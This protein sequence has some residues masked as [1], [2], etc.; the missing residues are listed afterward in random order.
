[1][2][3]EIIGKNSSLKNLE[4]HGIVSD[5][6]AARIMIGLKSRRHS[7][8]KFLSIEASHLSSNSITGLME[9]FNETNLHHIR[10]NP[11]LLHCHTGM[12]DIYCV[13]LIKT[14][15]NPLQL[16]ADSEQVVTVACTYLEAPLAISL[17]SF[18][19]KNS[20]PVASLDLSRNFNKQLL[21]NLGDSGNRVLEQMLMYNK[22]I[23]TLN[24]CSL[25]NDTVLKCIARGM[26]YNQNVHTIIITISGVS[27]DALCSLLLSLS[28]F[29]LTVKVIDDVIYL[30][31]RISETNSESMDISTKQIPSLF[32]KP[33]EVDLSSIDLNR[34]LNCLNSGINNSDYP[35]EFEL[36][37]S[38]KSTPDERIVLDSDTIN[39]SL[40]RIKS[41]KTLK[42]CN[43]VTSDVISNLAAG[44]DGNNTLTH[45]ALHPK[46]LSVSNIKMIFEASS[47]IKLEFINEFLFF[48][49]KK[50]AQW[51]LEVVKIQPTILNKL[52]NT[53]GIEIATII[54]KSEKSITL[55]F[56]DVNTKLALSLLILRSMA[57]GDYVVQVLD[58]TFN[59]DYID[60][61]QEYGNAIERMLRSCKS[62]KKLTIINL[63]ND[64]IASH[65]IKG[66]AQNSSLSKL[67][68]RE[69]HISNSSFVQS[70]LKMRIVSPAMHTICINNQISLQRLSQIDLYDIPIN[71]E[72]LPRDGSWKIMPIT[73]KNSLLFIFCL[74]NKIMCNACVTSVGGL[75][76]EYLQS[77][78]LSGTC[79]TYKQL[80]SLF[81]ELQEN[82][83]VINLDVSFCIYALPHNQELN[84]H[85]TLRGMLERN[86]TIKTLNLTG[87][88]DDK[89]A[90]ILAKAIPKCSLIAL[91]VNFTT[92]DYS[93]HEFE[94]LLCSFMHSKHLLT[95]E[96]TNFCIIQRKESLI[97][98]SLL[99]KKEC[100][101]WQL[102][103]NVELLQSWCILFMFHVLGK[104]CNVSRSGLCISVNKHIND[105]LMK[106]IFQMFFNAAKVDPG[107]FTVAK[108][109]VTTL[110]ELHLDITVQSFALFS[111]MIEPFT[112]LSQ[113]HLSHDDKC[114]TYPMLSCMY[115]KLISS[116]RTLEL[117]RFNGHFRNEM[118]NAIAEGLSHNDTL[119]TLQF[120]ATL[121]SVETL[122]HLFTSMCNSSLTCVQIIEGCCLKRL[123]SEQPFD[124]EFTGDK[125]LLCKLF[126]ASTRVN[127]KD[128]SFLISPSLLCCKELDLSIDS[129]S[130]T[131][132]DIDFITLFTA[133]M[134]GFISKLIL[135][136]NKIILNQNL[137]KPSTSILEIL[138]LD[139]CHI[140][141]C[142]CEHIAKGLTSNKC[143]KVL[144]LQHN[145]IT[146]CGA[147][148]ILSSLMKNN[149]LQSLHLSGNDLTPIKVSKHTS[150]DALEWKG[151]NSALEILNLGLCHPLFID[152]SS[153]L[154][155]YNTLKVL[156]LSI[157]EEALFA[158]I[159]HLLKDCPALEDLDI[160]ES[161]VE[162]PTTGLVIQQLLKSSHSI[163]SLNISSCN[164]PDGV[165]V[166]LTKGLEENK[167]L[168]KLD[169]SG[170]NI[171]GLGV[172][173]IFSALES[174]KCA[175]VELNLSSNWIQYEQL[176]SV[177]HDQIE[178]TTI[179]SKN[180]SLKTLIVS[181]FYPFSDWF[182]VKLFEGLKQNN[183]LQ[184]LDI[185]DNV[186]RLDTFNE[187]L[188]MLSENSTLSELNV[189]WV[190][191][192]PSI[193][194]LTEALLR[195]S[196]LKVITVDPVNEQLL[197][198][199]D[200]LIGKGISIIKS[201]GGGYSQYV[202]YKDSE[203]LS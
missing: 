77:F 146:S 178:S 174:N 96:V 177:P 191:F 105:G 73:D 185:S 141:D 195:C 147:T 192:P 95:L 12:F 171:C 59:V 161:S 196:S 74:L 9:I 30:I 139:Y 23:T 181:E 6:I 55:K 66:L 39:F 28:H 113:L 166:L 93:F 16:T 154:N 155:I 109:L 36:S 144:D 75:M 29:P 15:G 145:D 151:C 198:N 47:I 102:P 53:I 160:A 70:L 50:G 57:K 153:V 22:T 194:G 21:L 69:Y 97:H 110:Q 88:V 40:S 157:K 200:Q 13:E 8:V 135:T 48:R 42:L 115:K 20:S 107:K 187:F 111:I 37:F 180:S 84:M 35:R 122:A 120:S 106:R 58:L 175:L 152:F 124:T 98:V 101:V 143:L 112:N 3:S 32:F 2:S 129:A 83:S 10:F 176:S 86:T 173:S 134:E 138:K 26:A 116:N 5:T 108:N 80:A 14:S 81:E 172:L 131:I 54:D 186:I 1:M 41:L 170:N 82:T 99:T 182:G 179:L 127:P 168:E 87:I 46:T 33:H 188:S 91:S 71:V 90:A 140:T 45:L 79:L 128:K 49:D 11:R 38:T 67:Y 164:I 142:D 133:T 123:G 19:Q 104:H 25:M 94:D 184:K 163:K 136:R 165:C 203:C 199:K 130:Y 100:Q 63:T 92:K 158:N 190:E 149:T 119:Q 167:H 78:D 44:L 56:P 148:L 61:P 85:H 118:A 65:L 197:M 159:I 24:F 121:L 117:I 27:D 125:A 89:A 62:L 201:V 31:R 137:L 132:P 17:F 150:A 4:L 162:T 183:V 68:V 126:C 60:N 64:V 114:S 7:S 202:Y 51:K 189:R 156:T 169:L 76:L 34:V 52:L 43:P 193:D 103:P 72:D 18:L